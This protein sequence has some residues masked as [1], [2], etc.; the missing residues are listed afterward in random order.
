M[1]HLFMENI[2]EE[3]RSLAATLKG[4]SL[5]DAKEVALQ[6]EVQ[7]ITVEGA[8]NKLDAI[9]SRIEMKRDL[10]RS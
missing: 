8:T 10:M 5:I 1:K 6:R 4:V 9:I 7:A 3:M 2:H